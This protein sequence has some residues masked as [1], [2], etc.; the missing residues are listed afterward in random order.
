MPFAV[1]RSAT[2]LYEQ[3][4]NRCSAWVGW[5]DR[6]IIDGLINLCGW[7]VLK[8]AE[9]ARRLQSGQVGDYVYAIVIGLV[10]LTAAGVLAP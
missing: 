5:F 1:D 7:A 2:W 3:G 6:F 8:A 9:R 4:L 10:V